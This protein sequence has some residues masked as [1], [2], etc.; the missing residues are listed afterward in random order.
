MCS[1]ENL[2]DMGS[3][4]PPHPFRHLFGQARHSLDERRIRSPPDDDDFLSDCQGALNL[5]ALSPAD[6]APLLYECVKVVKSLD[7][8]SVLRGQTFAS[9]MTDETREALNLLPGRDTQGEWEGQTTW[10]WRG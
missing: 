5:A 9:N 1:I 8:G 10:R 3:V 2:S 6:A 4:P 7:F